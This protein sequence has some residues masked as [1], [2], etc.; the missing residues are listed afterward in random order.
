[1]M[2]SA[3]NTSITLPESAARS[4]GKRV[5]SG[6]A[7]SAASNTIGLTSDLIFHLDPRYRRMPEAR[8]KTRIWNAVSQTFLAYKDSGGRTINI[9]Q[10]TGSYGAAVISNT[11]EPPDRNGTGDAIVRG[12][13]SLVFHTGKNVASEFLPDIFRHFRH[14]RDKNKASV[15]TP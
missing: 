8:V 15:T 11:W 6:E 10:I 1:M 3:P 5:G 2:P 13:W 4:Y 9:S 12:T 14:S 7:I